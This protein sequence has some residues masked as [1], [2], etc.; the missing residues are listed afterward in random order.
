[1]ALLL[2]KLSFD[3]PRPMILTRNALPRNEG[4][5]LENESLERPFECT[6]VEG[7]GTKNGLHQREVDNSP[8][9]SVMNRLRS[10]DVTN[11]TL[12][13]RGPAD[14]DLRKATWW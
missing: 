5:K 12:E 8:A 4:V 9:V 3:V 2:A 1:M 7:T 10:W 13:T 14:L 11:S 6:N